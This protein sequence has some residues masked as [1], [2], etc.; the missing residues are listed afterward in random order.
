[1]IVT[2]VS[3]STRVNPL[4]PLILFWLGE[5]VI[6]SGAES[7]LLHRLDNLNQR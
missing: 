4:N 5:I 1:M 3:N 6:S 2:T 7:L